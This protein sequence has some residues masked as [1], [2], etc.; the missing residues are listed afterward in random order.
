MVALTALPPFNLSASV[1]KIPISLMS[2][3]REKLQTV[4]E[5]TDLAF[6]FAS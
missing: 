4:S 3:E 2:F 6:I 1:S 5:S